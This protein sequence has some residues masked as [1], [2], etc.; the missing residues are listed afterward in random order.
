MNVLSP[1]LNSTPLFSS[2]SRQ[3]QPSSAQ[4]YSPDRFTP[5]TSKAQQKILF[6][7]KGPEHPNDSSSTQYVSGV[8]QSPTSAATLVVTGET[9]PYDISDPDSGNYGRNAAWNYIKLLNENREKA[10]EAT[11][12]FSNPDV[13][14]LNDAFGYA[15]EEIKLKTQNVGYTLDKLTEL[16][17]NQ[18]DAKLFFDA[19]NQADDNSPDEITVLEL[20]AYLLFQMNQLNKI[21]GIIT[22]SQIDSANSMVVDA[23][24]ITQE[25]ITQIYRLLKPRYKNF[26]PLN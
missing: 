7:K 22:P 10:Q 23:N 14:K 2:A 5:Q 8:N 20:A 4:P 18:D 11:I 6:G 3:Y 16:F 13:P 24:E 25:Y 26:R 12:Q 1:T 15:E 19:V 17:G 21:D 9:G